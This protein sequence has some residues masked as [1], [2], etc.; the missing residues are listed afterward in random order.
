MFVRHFNGPGFFACQT[1]GN[2]VQVRKRW[3][4]EKMTFKHVKAEGDFTR[5][6]RAA[7]SS[8]HRIVSGGRELSEKKD[9]NIVGE[10][11]FCLVGEYACM[12]KRC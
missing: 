8:S 5:L 10:K 7:S 6:K 12:W 1:S 9:K 2:A 3:L 11:C 4:S